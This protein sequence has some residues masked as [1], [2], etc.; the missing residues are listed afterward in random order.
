MSVSLVHLSNV[1][2]ASE[3]ADNMG[4]QTLAMMKNICMRE[5]GLGLVI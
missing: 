2:R 1:L 5:A 4:M 3:H